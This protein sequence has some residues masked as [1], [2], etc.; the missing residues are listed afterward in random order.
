MKHLRG[1]NYLRYKQIFLSQISAETI[2]F[3]ALS[4]TDSKF[5]ATVKI[6][7]PMDIRFDI[8]IHFYDQIV[9]ESAGADDIVISETWSFAGMLEFKEAEASNIALQ[10]ST[11][12]C[13]RFTF[14][15][16]DTAIKSFGIER[17]LIAFDLLTK[18]TDAGASDIVG[19][20]SI[21][22]FTATIDLHNAWIDFPHFLFD[23]KTSG[24]ITGVD[25]A[26]AIDCGSVSRDKLKFEMLPAVS[27]LPDNIA[28]YSQSAHELS[29]AVYEMHRFTLYDMN[30]DTL[31][32][33]GGETL[34]TLG[35]LR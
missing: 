34:S 19:V 10:T 12:T 6:S 22:E 5:T 21:T 15:G 9:M 11:K 23:G 16:M 17:I 31:L 18:F 26:I 27:V 35:A 33:R 13:E 30:G 14:A 29:F 8:D 25:D 20:E 32:S 3:Y 2:Y 7:L 1:S 24:K 28:A 4:E